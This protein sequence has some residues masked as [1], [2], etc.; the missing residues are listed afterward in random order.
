MSTHEDF[1]RAEDE[2]GPSDRAFG[3]VF[4]AFLV[5]AGL[6]PAVHSRPVRYWALAL[7]AAIGAVTLARPGL[8]RVLNRGWTRF[9]LLLGRVV[10]PIIMALL[11]WVVI[12]PAGLLMRLA[13]KDPMRRRP[14]PNAA[15]YWIRRDPPGPRAETMSQQF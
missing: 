5:L 13:G 7:A 2:R 3:I 8:L 14:D 10:N 11:Y 1:S 6:W 9:G 4:T 15:S 12:T